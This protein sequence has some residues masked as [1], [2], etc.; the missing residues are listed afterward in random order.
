[1][2]LLSPGSTA[3]SRLALTFVPVPEI[4]LGVLQGNSPNTFYS[5]GGIPQWVRSQLG[6]SDALGETL[7]AFWPGQFFYRA[8]GE[9]F[10]A[11]PLMVQ[12]PEYRYI[13]GWPYMRVNKYMLGGYG[14]PRTDGLDVI[15]LTVKTGESV[16]LWGGTISG[17][18]SGQY[19]QDHLN[20]TLP[21]SHP[22]FPGLQIQ[23]S[24]PECMGGGAR[25]LMPQFPYFQTGTHAW[26][27]GA[28]DGHRDGV[29]LVLTSGS[30]SVKFM[31][32]HG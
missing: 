18:P 32:W 28:P 21:Q 24:S 17:M 4:Y 23:Y 5:M 25:L 13:W 31:E 26:L 3:A 19:Y 8:G 27:Y 30:D 10:I 16:T 14:S 6:P 7:K 29:I 9:F 11:N 1:M 15:R 22:D 2:S 20:P 12:G